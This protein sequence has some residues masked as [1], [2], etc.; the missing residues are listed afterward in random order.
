[1]EKEQAAEIFSQMTISDKKNF[2]TQLRNHHANMKEFTDMNAIEHAL[3][4]FAN[5]NHFTDPSKAEAQAIFD[6]LI[7]AT[8]A[9]LDRLKQATVSLTNQAKNLRLQ[10]LRVIYSKLELGQML[11]LKFTDMEDLPQVTYYDERAYCDKYGSVIKLNRTNA[12]DVIVV[13]QTDINT[14]VSIHIDNISLS[15]VIAIAEYI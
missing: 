3:Q 4:F 7:Y 14:I 10:A 12:R 2:L 9:D 6:K 1:M 11:D 5:D 15:H 13:L 8:M